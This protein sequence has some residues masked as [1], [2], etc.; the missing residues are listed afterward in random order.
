HDID[1]E[2]YF[3]NRVPVSGDYAITGACYDDAHG[4]NS[5]S[6]YIFSIM[7]APGNNSKSL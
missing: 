4:I 5:G 2:D 7:P 3:G 1:V 6:A